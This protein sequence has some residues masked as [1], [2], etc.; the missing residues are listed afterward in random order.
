MKNGRFNGT[1]NT[2]IFPCKHV[3]TSRMDQPKAQATQMPKITVFEQPIKYR[4]IVS[5][6]VND[7]DGERRKPFEKSKSSFHI[8]IVHRQPLDV[9]THAVVLT[10]VFG[11]NNLDF[12]VEWNE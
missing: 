8:C 12:F 1:N 3:V 9:E 2:N 4:N 6:G 10:N 11:H 5:K 7:L